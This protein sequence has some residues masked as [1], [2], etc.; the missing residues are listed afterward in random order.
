MHAR[1]MSVLIGAMLAA[2]LVWRGP[3]LLA[4]WRADRTARELVHALYHADSARL[5][6]I[7]ASGSARNLLCARRLWPWPF[8]MGAD[9]SALRPEP[10]R[11]GRGAYG[12]RTVGATLPGTSKRALFEF[13]IELRNPT[14]VTYIFADARTGV[15][16]DTVRACMS[17]KPT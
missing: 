10:T 14:K 17:L 11:A 7:S 9:G 8:W 4:Q 5:T 13:Y 1:W 6:R 16:N 12:Y 3:A 15:W 2:L